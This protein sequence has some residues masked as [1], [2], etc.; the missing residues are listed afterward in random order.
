MTETTIFQP[1]LALI[2]WTWVMW[3]W[4]YATRLPAIGK[5]PTL[6]AKTWVG[7]TGR[8]LDDALPPRVQWVAHNYNHLFEQPVLFYALTLTIAFLGHGHGINTAIA[9]AYVGIRIVHS[10]F[11]AL[12]N[13]VVVRFVLFLLGSLC[14]MSLTVHATY[15]AFGWHGTPIVKLG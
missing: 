14:L 3:A 13:R 1:V 12:V 2:I 10:L 8:Q 15:Y 4:M 9:W 5:A 7:G 11:Q 6:D